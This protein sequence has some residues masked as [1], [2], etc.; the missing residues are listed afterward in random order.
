MKSTITHYILLTIA[1]CVLSSCSTQNNKKGSL[2]LAQGI[3]AGEVTDQSAILQ[4]RITSVPNFEEGDVPGAIGVVRFHYGTRSEMD[5]SWQETVWIETKAETDWIAKV[6]IISLDP[7][8]RYHYLAEYGPDIGATT[9]SEPAHFKTHPG[10][11]SSSPISFAV[12]TGMNYY[13]FHYGKYDSATQYMGEDKHLGYPAL[14]AIQELSPDYFIGTGDNV[15][16]DH[17]AERGYQQALKKGKNPLPGLFGGKEV[18][19][20]T[21]MRRKYHVQF[22]QARFVELFANLGT[23]WM[24]DDHDYRVN[25]SDPYTEFPISHELGIRN[26]REQLPVIF[27]IQSRLPTYR[28]YQLS[29]D[30]QI[31]LIEGRDYR[32][33]NSDPDGPD[34]SIWGEKQKAWI[35]KT[36]LKSRA[37]FKFFLSPTPM[38]GPDD[39]YKTDNHVNHDGFRHEGDEFF[40]WL[41]ENGFLDKHFY[42]L[43]GDRH[44]QYHAIHPSGFEEFSCGA[45]VDA[46]SRAGRLAGDPKST[47][48]DSLI[49]Q[50]YI[51]G[52][53]SEASGGFLHVSVNRTAQDEP[54]ATFS[55]Y[56]EQGHVLY[57]HEKGGE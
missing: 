33:A 20:E 37:T 32:S 36:L 16:F 40:A 17:P 31:W 51:Q 10:S 53:A 14:Q 11:D 45:L 27:P 9:I 28:T 19:D 23:Y 12:V 52:K 38:V 26:F 46:N 34:K 5:D 43:C 7:G 1:G 42:F 54:R 56:D 57:Q 29:K 21:G 15:Y 41:G 55:F 6:P 50:P 3:M 18:I 47:D 4:T 44:W 48:P 39:A 2:F 49:S 13:H 30:V 22:I 35:K 25:D 8:T 24:K